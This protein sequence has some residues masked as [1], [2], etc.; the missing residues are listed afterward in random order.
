MNG[1]GGRT[2]R[3]DP[4]FVITEE[5]WAN[6]QLSVVRYYGRIKIC[7]HNYFICDKLGRDILECS[8]IADR[9]GRDKAIE[10]GEPMDLVLEEFIPVY[11]KLG[12]EAVFRMLD[13]GRM[14]IEEAYEKAGIEKKS[15]TTRQHNHEEKKTKKPHDGKRSERDRK[16]RA[17]ESR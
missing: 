13:Q 14:T 6:T 3:E 1:S 10:P 7:G 17:G 4:P 16:K 12:R 2:W 11:R 15:S 8:A 5:Y 9:E